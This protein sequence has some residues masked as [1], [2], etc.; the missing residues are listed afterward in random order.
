MGHRARGQMGKVTLSR[1]ASFEKNA[2]ENARF[3]F[4]GRI[5]LSSVPANIGSRVC[6]WVGCVKWFKNLALETELSATGLNYGLSPN[7][8]R[9]GSRGNLLILCDFQKTV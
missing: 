8:P 4:L 9:P 3:A 1:A 6:F 7:V 2:I 5:G